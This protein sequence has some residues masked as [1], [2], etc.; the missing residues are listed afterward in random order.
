MKTRSRLS[1]QERG[2][3][4]YLTAKVQQR[5]FGDPQFEP[6]Y[7][8]GHDFSQV[9]LFSHT[10][11]RPAVQAKLAIGQVNDRYEQEA[12]SVAAQVLAMPDSAQAVQRQAGRDAEQPTPALATTVTPLGPQ[13][14][15]AAEAETQATPG[16]DLENQLAGSKGSG[17]PLPE[18]IRAFM[19][20]RFGA[21]FSQVRV[22]TGPIALQMTQDLNAQAFT[23]GS[24]I[25][26]GAG[27]APDTDALTAHE[28]THVVQQGGSRG[29]Q[30]RVDREPTG[31]PKH[32]QAQAEEGQEQEVS[33]A[34]EQ[35]WLQAKP[36]IQTQAE[37][38]IQRAWTGRRQLKPLKFLG[39]PWVVRKSG[40]I[41]NLRLFHEHIFFED[42][43]APPNWG[44]MGKEGVAEDK[45]EN[46][47]SYSPVRTGLDDAKMRQAVAQVK[48]N[49]GEYS[50]LS[51]NC[52]DYVQKILRIYD[53]MADK[54]ASE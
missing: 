32:L 3:A 27:K 31:Q 53:G 18:N 28:L 49:P 5:P 38:I 12:D 22:H 47:G 24:D 6:F 40:N 1:H 4:K 29:Q 41:V 26:F 8:A 23:H 54:A 15:T 13:A 17:T 7:P 2:E 48:V 30:P 45:A 21:D 16:P 52:Q 42:G 9:D 39:K 20:P 35:E 19:E 11:H 51:N 43:L 50:L 25:Y 37:P 44:H 34:E 46:L 33:T 10:P 36:Q 14:Q